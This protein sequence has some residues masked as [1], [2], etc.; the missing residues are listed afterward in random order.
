MYHFIDY[1]KIHIMYHIMYHNMNLN[2]ILK[3]YAKLISKIQEFLILPQRNICIIL[4]VILRF[5]L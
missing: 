3:Y 4:L 5:I 2:I 1:I